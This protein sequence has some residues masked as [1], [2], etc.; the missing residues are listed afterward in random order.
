MNGVGHSVVENAHGRIE[1]GNT[2]PFIT[3]QIGTDVPKWGL[4]YGQRH[5]VYNE[6]ALR[7]SAAIELAKVYH[8]V[9]ANSK[10]FSIDLRKLLTLGEL[11]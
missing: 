2:Y 5:R 11:K 1:V 6:K 4:T 7:D 3:S 8:T 10:S 9:G